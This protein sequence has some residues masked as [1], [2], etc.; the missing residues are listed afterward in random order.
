MNESLKIKTKVE[1][2]K[3]SEPKIRNR[4]KVSFLIFYL[5]LFF[6]NFLF[7]EFQMEWFLSIIVIILQSFFMYF[8]SYK[9]KGSGLLT[10]F[11]WLS[12]FSFFSVF[13]C[14]FIYENILFLVFFIITVFMYLYFYF[15][16]IALRKVNRVHLWPEEMLYWKNRLK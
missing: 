3:N 14:N 16:S 12:P 10:A 15:C 5:F 9:K 11:L 8:F 2:L 1:F 4:W 7:F 13:R 6:E